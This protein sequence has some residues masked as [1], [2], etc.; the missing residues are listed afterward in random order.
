MGLGLGLGLDIV[1]LLRVRVQLRFR[2][3]VRLN[4]VGLVQHQTI[5]TAYQA[6]FVGLLRQSAVRHSN[7]FRIRVGVRFRVGLLRVRVRVRIRVRLTIV[8]LL[9]HQTIATAY[10][11]IFVEYTETWGY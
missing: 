4:I 1:E 7:S 11:A 8:G 6:I 10:Q 2:I 3:R 9:Q 5:A